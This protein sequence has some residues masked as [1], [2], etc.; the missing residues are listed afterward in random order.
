MSKISTKRARIWLELYGT[1]I[2][3]DI[4]VVD[5]AAYSFAE[6]TIK[7]KS[8]NEV[9]GTIASET[10]DTTGELSLTMGD[11]GYE[12]Y[13]IAVRASV[14]TGAAVTAGTFEFPA[15]EKGQS[16]RLPNRNVTT[17]TVPGKTAG[18]DYQL[19]RSS[20]VVTLLADNTAAI[21]DCTYSSGQTKKAGITAG[22]DMYFTVHI[23]DELNKEYTVLYRARAL[24]PESVALI[25][26]D[27]FGTL[28]IKFE[29]LLDDSKPSD[30]VMGQFGMKEE[31]Q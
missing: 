8:T 31:A 9:K 13:V 24:L 21:S 18:V 2:L 14:G 25:S 29:L 7:K 1:G 12:N 27:Q 16:F 17:L 30:D 23:G 6:E 11:T 19:Y 10:I 20:G 15:L 3:T 28:P 26:V 4:G 5:E 22:G